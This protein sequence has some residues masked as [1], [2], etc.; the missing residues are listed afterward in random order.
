MKSPHARAGEF[1]IV[2][3]WSHEDRCY[4]V[5]VPDLPG[6]TCHGDSREE[7]ARHAEEAIEFYLAC[8]EEDGKPIPAP[9]SRLAA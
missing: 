9:R 3:D 6:C 5:K 4:V 2:I 8:L 1:E 7:A